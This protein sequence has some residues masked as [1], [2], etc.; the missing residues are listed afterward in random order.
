MKEIIAEEI[1]E[2]E[3]IELLR[4]VSTPKFSNR[5]WNNVEKQTTGC[6]NWK[7]SVYKKGLPYG[8][9]RVRKKKSKEDTWRTHL[10]TH[11]AAYMIHNETTLPKGL[12]I[13]HEC[14]NARCCNP[15]H[16]VPKTHEENM[17]DMFGGFRHNS[18]IELRKEHLENLVQGFTESE[19]KFVFKILQA[20]LKM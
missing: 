7:L 17:K 12:V 5:F 15:E 6:W 11:Q 9:V 1:P 14:N 8:Q 2:E 16:L 13:G 19:K 18:Q 3:Q 10:R 4:I 20:Q